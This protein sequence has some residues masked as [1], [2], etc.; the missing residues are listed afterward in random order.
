MSNWKNILLKVLWSL[1]CIAMIVLFVFA[2]RAK[3]MK[4]CS[5]IDIVLT[6]N[7]GNF[8]FMDEKEILKLIN[9]Q[10]IKEGTPI[11][12]IQLHKLEEVFM[13][14]KWVEHA[15]VYLDNQQKLI[16]NIE[17]KVPVARVFT[18]SGTS[19]YI[20]NIA[21]KL[22]LR[23]LSVL[24]LPVF[25]GFPSDLDKLSKPDSALL[26]DVLKFA[27]VIQKD[28]FFNAQIAQVNIAP[29][30]DFEMI[31]TLGSHTV[32]IG[33]V[34]RIEDKLNRLFTFY[35]KVLVPSGLNAYE[36]LDL[37]FDHQLVALKKGL[38]PIQYAEGAMPTINLDAVLQDTLPQ[39][40]TVKLVLQDSVRVTTAQKIKD[41]SG[42]KTDIKKIG[43]KPAQSGDK[44]TAPLVKKNKSKSA[45]QTIKKSNK[46]NNK[47]LNNTK[48]APRALL[49]KKLASTNNKTTKKL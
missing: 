7:T 10:G 5:G 14:T 47:T 12:S 32:L 27:S 22:P 35:K 26:Q 2:W 24:R 44:K 17:Q 28:S 46:T 29:N 33:K 4:K 20:D 8:I 23:Q 18:V 25:T 40:D 15:K 34:E 3:S 45:K 31:P 38:Q 43:T 41:S 6:G 49:P 21:Q 16:I 9:E 19:F 36:V 11:A 37:R 13:A 30:G 42:Q 48:A 39:K 1:A